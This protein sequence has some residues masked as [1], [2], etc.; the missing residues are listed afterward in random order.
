MNTKSI[1]LELLY[2]NAYGKIY[3]NENY[4]IIDV[5]TEEP[6]EFFDSLAKAATILGEEYTYNK[7]KSFEDDF[8]YTHTACVALKTCTIINKQRVAWNPMMAAIHLMAEE[9]GVNMNNPI[10]VTT[11]MLKTISNL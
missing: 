10:E 11:F 5:E 7:N 6:E 3:I 2:E 8:I 1:E 9:E 4:H